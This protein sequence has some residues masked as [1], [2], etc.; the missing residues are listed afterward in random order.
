M[1]SELALLGVAY[2]HFR[3]YDPQTCGQVE[4]FHQTLKKYLGRQRGRRPSASSR[5]SWTASAPTT[6]TSGLT[7][8]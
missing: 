5:S 7:G 4:R 2:K 3:P 1:E 6:T 8:S